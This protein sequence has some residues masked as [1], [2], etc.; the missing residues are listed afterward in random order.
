MGLEVTESTRTAMN[1]SKACRRP[2]STRAAPLVLACLLGACAQAP[3]EPGAPGASH[4]YRSQQPPEQ[5]ARC[6][7]RNAEE[8]SSALRS[9]V[10]A[11]DGRAEVVV[12]VQNGVTYASADF[13]P[14]GSGSVGR[15]TL[16]VVT[17][18]RQGD[19]LDALTQGC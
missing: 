14:S 17:S 13:R 2:P 18:G 8:H 19:L 15:I 10:T 5:A 7:G 12:S 11:R 3:R 6:F 16:N 1:D 4:T 9:A